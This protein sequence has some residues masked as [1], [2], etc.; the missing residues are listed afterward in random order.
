MRA[1]VV[2]GILVAGLATPAPAE[3]RQNP[4]SGKSFCVL[5]LMRIDN[6]RLEMTAVAGTSLGGGAWRHDGLGAAA[7]YEIADDVVLGGELRRHFA[8]AREPAAMLDTPSRAGAASLSLGYRIVNGKIQ[9]PWDGLSH[10]DLVAS[11]GPGVVWTADE[12]RP[13][14]A[15][16][17][18][19][20]VFV[21]DRI[22][23][24]LGLHDDAVVGIARGSAARVI[25]TPGTMAPLPR[26]AIEAR[27]GIGVWWPG[28]PHYRCKRICR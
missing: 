9:H 14:I 28:R 5:A 7:R 15:L 10:L 20:R 6:D 3:R 21:T 13:A 26:H 12:L 19:L 8:H 4:L 11:I 25:D 2:A 22:T 17:V 18:T 1:L 27:V 24:H 16:D 23:L